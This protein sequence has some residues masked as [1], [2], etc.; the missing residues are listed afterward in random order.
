MSSAAIPVSLERLTIAS[1]ISPTDICPVSMMVDTF[2]ME[3][4]KSTAI[5]VAA[6][7]K[8]AI[9]ADTTIIF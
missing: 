4:S 5:F 8:V 1:S 6:V 9:P 3:S 2:A 7:A